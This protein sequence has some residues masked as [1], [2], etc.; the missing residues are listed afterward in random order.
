MENKLL[1]EQLILLSLE[2]ESML[3][4]SMENDRLKEMLDL[5]QSLQIN[6]IP[7]KV[8]SM[9]LTANLTAITINIGSED[10]VQKNDPV[11]THLGVIGKVY[12]V[13][14]N[15]STIQLINDSDFRMGVK[16]IPSAET[17]ILRWKS[18]NICEVREVYK[19]AEINVGDIVTTSGL[20]DI[21]P[22]DLPVGKVVSVVNDRIQ[23]QKIVNVKIDERLN[24]LRYVFVILNRNN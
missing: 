23:F 20:S 15:Y 13:S 3:V 10:G 22:D 1:R 24:N 12:S 2:K 8:T 14:N 19:N 7:T 6:L 18:N 11:M 4:Q 5:K 17:G 9:G 16:F 21:F